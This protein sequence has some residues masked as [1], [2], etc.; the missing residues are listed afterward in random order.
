MA[1]IDKKGK[2]RGKIGNY[3]HR[4][5]NG[6]QVLQS[7]PGSIKPKGGTIE[8]NKHFRSAAELSGMVYRDLKNYAWDRSYSYL[9][10]RLTG[11][12]RHLSLPDYE[13]MEGGHYMA[14]DRNDSLRHL[15][16]ILPTAVKTGN[17]LRINIPKV[18]TTKRNKKL[19]NADYAAYEVTLMGFATDEKDESNPHILQV[20]NT[21]RFKIANG[22]D[23]KHIDI[24]LSEALT[25][26]S[27]L[28]LAL[29]RAELF[30]FK[31]SAAFLNSKEI[32]PVSILGTWK[33]S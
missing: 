19:A 30:Q 20:V 33:L 17:R 32:N 9:H 23:K 3:I 25:F 31:N 14:L 22:F 26:N 28:L 24:D 8:M 5:V 7:T 2:I 6:K 13:E 18:N 29:I 11:L 10:G 16:P 21:D 27:G 15:F 1:I 12:L 4:E